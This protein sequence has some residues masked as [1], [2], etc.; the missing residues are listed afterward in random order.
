MYRQTAISGRASNMLNWI[1][2]RS[3]SVPWPNSSLR[4]SLSKIGLTPSAIRS[5]RLAGAKSLSGNWS[6]RMTMPTAIFCSKSGSTTSLASAPTSGGCSS[7]RLVAR[8]KATDGRQAADGQ[9][10][11]DHHQPRR[12]RHGRRVEQ[13]SH[14]GQRQDH[15]VGNDQGR[16]GAGEVAAG[17]HADHAEER[18]RGRHAAVG[19]QHFIRRHASQRQAE[20]DD[21]QRAEDQHRQVAQRR[22]Q[23]AQHHGRG[24]H[25]AG[26]QHFV[27]LPFLFARDR[28]GGEA[29]NHQRQ[30]GILA[31]EEQIDQPLRFLRRCRD[32]SNRAWLGHAT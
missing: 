6:L 32:R 16:D 31:Q 29:G 22:Q 13:D 27:G 15:Q 3:M 1:T 10:A 5:L 28:A 24:P 21:R 23:L 9:H 30:Q 26:Q 8:S 14:Q 20:H 2:S 17:R 19:R 12:S 25:R 18:H 7:R 11:A 4:I